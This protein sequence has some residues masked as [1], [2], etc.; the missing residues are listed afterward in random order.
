MKDAKLSYR[1]ITNDTGKLPITWEQ[2]R[3][4]FLTRAAYLVLKFNIPEELFVNMDETPLNHVASKGKTWAK[5]N[6]D[7]IST[8]GGK[9][10]RQATGTPWMNLAGEIIF[11][12]TTINGKTQR[13]LPKKEFRDRPAMKKIVFGYSENHWVSKETMREQVTD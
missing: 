3:E 10:K 7:N 11:F 9:D 12:H 6:S 8:H 13:C 4:D 1:K 2:D 5:T